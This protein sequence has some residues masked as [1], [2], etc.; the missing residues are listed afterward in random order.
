M[1][2]GII[3]INLLHRSDRKTS[4]LKNL[5]D[6][7][8][9]M[10]KVHRLDAVLHTICGHIG[11]GKSHIKALK[12][13]IKNNWEETL[14][15]E[16]DFVFSQP[17][18]VVKNMLNNIQSIQYDV[19]LLA[20]GY[21][22]LRPSNYSFLNTVI[23]C[24]TTSG[25]IIKR[26][27]YETLLNNFKSAVKV[28]KLKL[29]KHTIKCEQGQVPVSKLVHCFAAIDQYWHRLQRKDTFYITKPLLG[30]QLASYSDNNCSLEY[31]Q[32]RME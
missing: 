25:Y 21:S 29:Q 31:Q 17:V 19:V 15:V 3:Y 18:D 16:D 1:I 2:E 20:E 8:F 22:V 9:D 23:K 5:S 24:T 4:I 6:Y 26:H 27:Y 11:C 12:M 30:T 14:I 7:D 13:A 32:K 10:S 28:M